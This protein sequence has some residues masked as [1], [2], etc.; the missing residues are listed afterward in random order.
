MKNRIVLMCVVLSLA[1]STAL[2]AQET[3]DGHGKPEPPMA[4][5]HLAKGQASKTGGAAHNSPLMTNH[6]GSIMTTVQPVQAIFWGTNW[7]S[8]TFTGDKITG[9]DSFYSGIGN[10]GYADT[11][12]E[13]SDPSRHILS[14]GITYNGHVIDTTPATSGQRTSPILAEVCKVITSP[15]ANGYYPV[16]V[17]I[18]R[19]NAGYCAWHS[20][21]TCNGVPVQFAFFFHLDG[22]PGCDPEDTSGLHSQ[23]LAALANVSGHELS[24]ART[25]PRLNAWYDNSGAENGDKCAWTFGTPLLTFKNNSQ[26]KIQGNWSNEAYTN[27]TGYPNATGQRGCIDGGSY[28]N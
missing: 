26:W 19:G 14:D 4:G 16:Y 10:T 15:Q 12:S 17:D 27:S 25:D 24:E 13:Y 11:C 7:N 28:H 5:L 3:E 2:F 18:P 6:G 8:A 22:D 21:G 23:G 1:M 20:A 9:M